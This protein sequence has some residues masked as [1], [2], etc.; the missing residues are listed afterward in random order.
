MMKS[1][2]LVA[3]LA[4][5]CTV[6]TNTS[7]SIDPTPLA[8]T[9]S[10][11]SWS[12]VAGNTDSFLSSGSDNY[13]ATLYQTAFTPCSGVE[14]SGPHLIVSIPKTTGDYTMDL[15]RNMTF[16]DGSDNKIATDGRIVVSSVNGTSVSGGLHG[17]YDALNEVSGQFTV[18]ICP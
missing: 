12:Y 9:V 14:P 6:T 4:G 17:T 5:A 2:L 15:S 8:G 1:A 13:Y 3:L 18:T 11:A 16:T 7:T 10:G